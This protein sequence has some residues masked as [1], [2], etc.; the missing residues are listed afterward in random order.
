M[1]AKELKEIILEVWRREIRMVANP[2]KWVITV[3]P[4]DKVQD[5]AEA[6]KA[7][8]PEL[9][10]RLQQPKGWPRYEPF[11]PPW[12]DRIALGFNIIKARLHE[13]ARCGYPVSVWVECQRPGWYCPKCGQPSNLKGNGHASKR[14]LSASTT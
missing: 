1:A 14:S 8:K 12:W 9:M 7:A 3:W 13:C 4:A 10:R 6:L 11:P 2:R 5:L